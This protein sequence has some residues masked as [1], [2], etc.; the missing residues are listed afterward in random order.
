MGCVFVPVLSWPSF[1]RWEYLDWGSQNSI[2]RI[3]VGYH[4]L[5]D[6]FGFWKWGGG[7]TYFSE[8]EKGGVLPFFLPRNFFRPRVLLL[9]GVL[10]GAQINSYCESNGKNFFGL[11]FLFLNCVRSFEIFQKVFCVGGV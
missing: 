5:G 1:G 3:F 8:F 4:I 10:G 2:Q 6:F 9:E 7:W 11:R